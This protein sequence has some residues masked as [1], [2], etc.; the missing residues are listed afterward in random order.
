MF[1]PQIKLE[2]VRRY[3]SPKNGWAVYVDID[4]SEEGHTGGERK[5]SDAKKRQRR[6]QAE[7]RK[8]RKALTGLGVTLGGGRKKWMQQNKLPQISGDRDLIAFHKESNVYVIAE[9]EGESSSQPE[10]KLYKAIGQLVMAAGEPEPSGWKR[11]LA[12][13]VGDGDMTRHLKRAEALTKLGISRVALAPQQK[14]DAWFPSDTPLS[15]L[16]GGE[17]SVAGMEREAVT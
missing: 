17:M 6:M 2:F 1:Q 14:A 12:L 13:V 10:Q 11:M 16:P 3:C 9:V 7:G 15:K 4:P 8:S 5:S